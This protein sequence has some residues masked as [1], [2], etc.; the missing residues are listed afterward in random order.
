MTHLLAVSPLLFR[1]LAPVYFVP[2]GALLLL[3]L[4]REM[5]RARL[6]RYKSAAYRVIDLAVFPLLV[7]FLLF[8][9]LRTYTMLR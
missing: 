8:A 1:Q 4:E 5:I 2:I 9:A 3:L 7:L 6:G